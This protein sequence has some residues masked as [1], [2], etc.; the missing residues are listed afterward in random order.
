MISARRLLKLS[1]LVLLML[2]A[3]GI[4]LYLADGNLAVGWR[5]N[6]VR[7]WEQYGLLTLKGKLVTNPG[8]YEALTRPEVYPGTARPA[9]IPCSL[10][11][12]SLAGP[13]RARC[14]FILF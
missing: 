12:G 10:S 4:L 14:P 13:G 8:G 2:A 6:V 1:L 3:S 7:N 11:S 9:F 5:N